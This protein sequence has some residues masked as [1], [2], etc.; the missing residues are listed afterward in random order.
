MSIRAH[1]RAVLA[2]LSTAMAL[3][4]QSITTAAIVHRDGYAWASGYAGSERDILVDGGA[5]RRVAW[6]TFQTDSIGVHGMVRADL[7]LYV[8]NIRSPGLVRV[9]ALESAPAAPETHVTL[10]DIDYRT[11][12]ADSAPLAT[13]DIETVMRLDIT[14]LLADTN[15]PFHG[16]ALTSDDGLRAAFDAKEG[17][18]QPYLRLTYAVTSTANRWYTGDRVPASG[19]GSDGDM[20]LHTVTGDVYRNDRGSWRSAGNIRGPDGSGFSWRGTWSTT[21]SYTSG[22]AVSY[23]GSSYMA[24]RSTMGDR[25]SS[26]LPWNMLVQAGAQAT[27]PWTDGSGTVTT[28]RNVGIGVTA[29][30]EALEIDGS[31]GV[32]GDIHVGGEI[33]AAVGIAQLAGPVAR[34]CSPLLRNISYNTTTLEVQYHGTL[35]T[36]VVLSGPAIAIDRIGGYVN[37]HR[38]DHSGLSSEPD[39]VVELYP[40][41]APV[42]QAY[43]DT[44]AAH[45][46]T[47]S[48]A[49][50][51]LITR[52]LYS[53]D[54]R[55]ERWNLLGFTPASYEPV[56]HSERT[57][58]TFSQSCPADNFWA[59]DN[60]RAA[61]FG[62]LSM[63]PS[64]EYPQESHGVD[65]PGVITGFCPLVEVDTVA[66]TVTLTFYRYEEG[67]A[68][69]SWTGVIVSTGTGGLGHKEM[70]VFDLLDHQTPGHYSEYSTTNCFIADTTTYHG[71]FPVSYQLLDGYRMPETM[72]VRAVIA[73]GYRED[74]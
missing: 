23:N 38:W 60:A 21:T 54:S 29:P 73:Y 6:L 16:L 58:F 32:T 8:K 33:R 70:R 35:D 1:S 34:R 43:F 28:L 39:F 36:A 69:R 13:A 55:E 67:D 57:R 15:R 11:A 62:E 68:I 19:T 22:D 63:S 17:R 2:V 18:L 48:V 71:C 45:P 47:T 9:H 41:E 59:Y 50:M 52:P 30:S 74:S 42:L 72:R 40:W 31:M 66:L 4:A 37:G 5:D 56:P 44:Y 14:P 46:E 49:A 26:G 25:P 64:L 53:G 51:S 61:A 65:I 12:A 3:H 27:S 20:Y 10:A 7:M 24:A